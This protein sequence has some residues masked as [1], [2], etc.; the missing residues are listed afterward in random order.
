MNVPFLFDFLCEIVEM[1][2]KLQNL[3][4][5]GDIWDSFPEEQ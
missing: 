4:V 5:P 2:M 1:K 3:K